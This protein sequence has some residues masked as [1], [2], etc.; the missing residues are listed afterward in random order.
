[1]TKAELRKARRAAVAAGQPLIGELAL[2]N[3]ADQDQPAEFSDTPR[4]RTA[5]HR[6][7]RYYDSLN[8]APE[9]E[10]DR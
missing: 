4:G 7:A 2:P 6:W 5:L 8:G 9:N 1:M 3:R 10:W